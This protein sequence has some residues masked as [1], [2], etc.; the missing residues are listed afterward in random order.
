MENT[1][2]LQIVD[3]TVIVLTLSV[4]L[5]IG[6]LFAVKDFK[7]VN[8][9][10]FLLGGRRMFMLPVALSIFATFTSGI[11]LVGMLTDIYMNGCMAAALIA[12]I[13]IGYIV[14][15]FTIVPL[16]YPLRL[17]SL[18]EYLQLRY[19]STTLRIFVVLVGMLQTLC[20]M[21]IA[22]LSPALAL[23]AGASLPMWVS[24]GIVGVIGTVYSAIGGIK[25]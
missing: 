18:Y 6:I 22:L 17:T 12:G 16:L 21:A 2:S 9:T 7:N 10:E 1:V 23:Q 13:T 11:A 20:Y 3:Y 14:A 15:A 5:G 8:R 4:S 19:H 25:S 24:V